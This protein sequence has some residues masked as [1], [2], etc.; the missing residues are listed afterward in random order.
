MN[1]GGD[2]DDRKSTDEFG[3]ESCDRGSQSICDAETDHGIS[4]VRD[5]PATGYEC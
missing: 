2:G 5:A 3:E 1:T 4:N